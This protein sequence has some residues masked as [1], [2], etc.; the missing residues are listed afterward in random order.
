M[1]STG[2]ESQLTERSLQAVGR[3]EGGI[4]DHERSRSWSRSRFCD[5][6][7]R[8]NRVI[9]ASSARG[10]NSISTDPARDPTRDPGD[11]KRLL[12]ADRGDPVDDPTGVTV[13]ALGSPSVVG[14]PPTLSSCSAGS[15]SL[16][17]GPGSTVSGSAQLS[18]PPYLNGFAGV[19]GKG[20]EITIPMECDRA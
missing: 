18:T 7:K 5:C 17:P 9:R 13:A 2:R 4:P 14:V 1:E 10:V 12:S 16:P 19:S 15:D 20:N 3:I 6:I 11:S 8:I